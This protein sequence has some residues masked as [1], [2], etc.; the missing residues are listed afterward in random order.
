MP[1]ATLRQNER[2]DWEDA[3]MMAPPAGHRL[4]AALVFADMVGYSQLMDKS[5]SEA[6][7]A[8]TRYRAAIERNVARYGGEVVQHYG[9][10]ALLL[11]VSAID[12]TRAARRIQRD[13]RGER[14]VDIRVGVHM[15]DVVRDDDGVYGTGV[16]VAARIQALCP[17]GGVLVSGVVNYEI[18]N[19]QGLDSISLGYYRLK[20]ID[21]PVEVCAVADPLLAV[22]TRES[23]D[24]PYVPWTDPPAPGSFVSPGGVA[25]WWPFRRLK[26]FFSELRRRKVHRVAQG[27]AV[28]GASGLGI[29]NV[30]MPM[31]GLHEVLWGWAVAATVAGVPVALGLSWMYD[32]SI[33]V[34]TETPRP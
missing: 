3:T 5:E 19:K 28:A 23:I 11:F 33:T 18:K 34:T 9:D 15:A 12:A 7:Q 30:L 26:T 25:G 10:G 14:R 32:L 8:R 21:Q 27:Y 24:A 2:T 29:F 17:P 16:N 31:M 20:N 13:L 1:R 6:Y 4:L 22:P